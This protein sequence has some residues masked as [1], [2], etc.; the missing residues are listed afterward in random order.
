MDILQT[1]REVGQLVKPDP[2]PEDRRMCVLCHQIGDMETN[3][4]SRLLNH[5]VDKWVH[6]NC[7]LWSTEVYKIFF[8]VLV[9][10]LFNIRSLLQRK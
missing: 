7:A 10:Q 4:A 8:A 9:I 5:D 6:L 2:L 3:M 1:L